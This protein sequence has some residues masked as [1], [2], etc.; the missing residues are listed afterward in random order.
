M[1]LPRSLCKTSLPHNVGIST[2]IVGNLQFLLFVR[3]YPLKLWNGTG[4]HRPSPGPVRFSRAASHLVVCSPR[5]H[6]CAPFVPSSPARWDRFERVPSQRRADRP[7]TAAERLSHSPLRVHAERSSELTPCTRSPA[8]TR[9]RPR[10][11]SDATMDPDDL[12]M[13]D[14]AGGGGHAAATAGVGGVGASHPLS[15]HVEDGNNTSSD[16]AHAAAASSSVSSSAGV[17]AASSAAS[18]V[19]ATPLPPPQPTPA[20]LAL[21]SRVAAYRASCLS[22][23]TQ[24]QT[25]H[26]I[27]H[28]G[29][30]GALAFSSRLRSVRVPVSLTPR[31]SCR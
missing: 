5:V 17:A 23:L 19:A 6:R 11:L 16:G 20:D 12:A 21:Q 31:S 15:V 8:L 30:V 14:D 1:D 27:P 3:P 9:P 29:K 18:A 28:S 2:F 22:I 10:A 4:E 7:S 24:F 13:H 25:H 26:L